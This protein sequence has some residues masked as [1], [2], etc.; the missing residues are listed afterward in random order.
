[1]VIHWRHRKVVL[2]HRR[3]LFVALAAVLFVLAL[4]APLSPAVHAAPIPGTA[5]H[6]AA[7]STTPPAWCTQW[8]IVSSPPPSGTNSSLNAVA[9]ASANDVWA[10]GS[11]YSA[12]GSVEYTLIEHFDGSAWSIVS[13]PNATASDYLQGVVALAANNVWAVGASYDS[14][15]GN[16]AALIAHY[17][18]SAW[19]I[20]SSPTLSGDAV[21][22]AIAADAAN[23]IWAVGSYFTSSSGSTVPLTEHFDGTSW[24]VV[25]APG[26]SGDDSFYGVSVVS[27]QAFAA[28]A[29]GGAPTVTLAEHYVSGSWT[30]MTTPNVATRGTPTPARRA[31]TQRLTSPRVAPRTRIHPNSGT[32]GAILEGIA[33]ISPTDVWAVGLTAGVFGSNNLI[34]HW[35]GS[36]WSIVPPGSNPM[37]TDSFGVAAVP[38][39]TTLWAVG[40]A[41][42]YIQQWLGSV[43]QSATV[44][45]PANS[46]SELLAVAAVSAANAW[47]VGYSSDITSGLSQTLIEHYTL[48]MGINCPYP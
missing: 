7:A 10:V 45:A 44:A 33:A 2:V 22:Y 16:H 43:W 46:S 17:D 15:S 34:E 41:G 24:S 38:G 14:V 18:G 3:T 29:S 23:D 1:M 30:I 48:S 9:A 21:L 37:P 39:A 4:A 20:A 25:S 27:G 35:D 5:T 8:R 42:P 11:Y 40:G 36:A 28:G 6:R 32:G 19:S 13:S 26:V 12:D 47:A 31:G